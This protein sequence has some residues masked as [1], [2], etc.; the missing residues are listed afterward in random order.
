[1]WFF[2]NKKQKRLSRESNIILNSNNELSSDI[3]VNVD[4]KVSVIALD[5]EASPLPIKVN[6]LPLDFKIDG[7]MF[8]EISDRSTISKLDG[9]FQ[10]G[11]QQALFKV[12]NN[13]FKNIVTQAPNLL[14]SDI[15]IDQLTQAKKHPGGFRAILMGEKGIEKNAILEK[16]DTSKAIDSNKLA[17]GV[18]K[19]MNLTSLIVGQY[20]MSQINSKLVYINQNISEIGNY[21]QREFKSRILALIHGIEEISVY[22]SE[23]LENNEL[24]KSELQQLDKY[25][26]D[27]IQLLEQVNITLKD[28]MGQDVTNIKQYEYKV[29][30]LEMLL[31]Y[32]KILLA[33]LEQ[34]SK[35]THALHLGTVSLNKC[36]SSHAKMLEKSDDCSEEVPY[37]HAYYAK[38]LGIELEKNRFK[39]QGFELIMTKPL[40][41]I[42]RKWDYKGLDDNLKTM[43]THQKQFRQ[44][45]FSEPDDSFNQDVEII[46]KDGKYYCVPRNSDI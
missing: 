36:F 19:V 11:A 15:P 20:N 18:A 21:Q 32:Q 24:R 30:E 29:N 23:I 2:K 13:D 14:R 46:I 26:N 41:M 1:M 42:D 4:S 31:G 9:V 10:V 3:A 39:K 12:A 44:T 43:I 34:S 33:I 8:Y 25:K 27:A 40:T 38:K 16:V 7:G 37:W 17:I 6:E 45:E 35:L 5:S 28:T 22:S